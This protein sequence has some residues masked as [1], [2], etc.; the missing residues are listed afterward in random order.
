[1]EAARWAVGDRWFVGSVPTQAEALK[2]NS[3]PPSGRRDGGRRPDA[4]LAIA[5]K[6]ATTGW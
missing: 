3:R 5:T 6:Q 4:I 1:M 2:W